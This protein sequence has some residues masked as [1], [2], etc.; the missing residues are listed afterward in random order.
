[1]PKAL[2]PKILFSEISQL[3]SSRREEAKIAPGETLG[4]HPY[5][6]PSPRRGNT[7]PRIPQSSALWKR[8]IAAVNSA[9]PKQ[10][11][12]AICGHK[13]SIPTPFR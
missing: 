4:K 3:Y 8:K 9:T 2:T 10:D 7:N 13:M 11:M 5:E 6:N 1:M 12:A